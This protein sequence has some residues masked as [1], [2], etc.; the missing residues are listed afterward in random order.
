MSSRCLLGLHASS[1]VDKAVAPIFSLCSSIILS[2]HID[3]LGPAVSTS[4]NVS[5]SSAGM[6]R[7]MIAFSG[8]KR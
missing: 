1:R 8:Q 7:Q 5:L 4:T 6:S 3:F 2:S